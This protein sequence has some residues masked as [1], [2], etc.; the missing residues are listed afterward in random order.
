MYA[1]QL[2]LLLICRSDPYYKSITIIIIEDSSY[3]SCSYA[4]P[5]CRALNMEMIL[6]GAN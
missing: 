6:G 3:C 4:M 2:A 1:D 5:Y